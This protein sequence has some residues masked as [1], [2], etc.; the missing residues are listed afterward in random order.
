MTISR[1]TKRAN[2]FADVI[3]VLKTVSDP[4]TRGKQFIFSTTNPVFTANFIG[5]PIIVLNKA[6]I[7][8]GHELFDNSY[9]DLAVPV[10][11]TIY[12]TDNVMLDTLSDSVDNVMVPSNFP[13]FTFKDFTER[14][15]SA[16]FDSINAY[17]RTMTYYVELDNL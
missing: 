10:K 13:Q 1:N 9:S 16:K 6:E 11:I 15:G 12:S 4:L 5:F 2:V 3:N 7:V 14:D 8:K 17:S